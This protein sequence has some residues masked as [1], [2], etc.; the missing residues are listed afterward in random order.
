MNFIINPNNNERISIFSN[1]GKQLLKSYVKQFIGGSQESFEESLQK[2][3]EFLFEKFKEELNKITDPFDLLDLLVGL[4]LE[5]SLGRCH[6]IR[7]L[8]YVSGR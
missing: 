2:L 4:F 3:K 6:H 8:E 1:K 5:V 7:P